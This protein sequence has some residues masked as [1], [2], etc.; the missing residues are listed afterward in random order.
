MCVFWVF[1]YVRISSCCFHSTIRNVKGFHLGCTQ[2]SLR[3]DFGKGS[4]F[5]SEGAERDREDEKK[6]KKTVMGIWLSWLPLWASGVQYHWGPQKNRVECASKLFHEGWE[7]RAFI[8]QFPSPNWSRVALRNTSSLS[9]LALTALD[10][11][12]RQKSYL[13]DLR[14]DVT[15]CLGTMTSDSW[16]H[17]WPEGTWCRAK[18]TC[19]SWPCNLALKPCELTNLHK[20]SNVLWNLIVQQIM[21]PNWHLI[22]GSRNAFTIQEYSIYKYLFE[23]CKC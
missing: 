18:S 22:W 9:L 8:H 23:S 11:A 7:A 13:S 5:W 19:C 16:N 15:A 20:C 4:L 12:L 1:E 3:Q 10:K 17:R 21:D 14:W 6:K 2:N